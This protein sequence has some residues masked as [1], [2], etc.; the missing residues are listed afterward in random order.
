MILAPTLA[1]NTPARGFDADAAAFAAR[2]GATDVAALSAFVKG[3]KELGLWN[4]MVCWPLRSS[5]NAGTGTTAY[6]LGGLGTFNGTLVNGPTWGADG[7][8][9]ASASSQSISTSLILNVEGS[10]AVYSTLGGSDQALFSNRP[11]GSWNRGTT[12]FA[13]EASDSVALVDVAG[14]A[15]SRIRASATPILSQFVF[16]QATH[17]S[18]GSDTTSDTTFRHNKNSRSTGSYVLGSGQ[19]ATSTE[20]VRLLAA[21][22]A[23]TF[24][25]FNGTISFLF[26]LSQRPTSLQ[27]E[28]IYDLYKQTLGSGLGLP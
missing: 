12:L 5:Q 8:A 25:Y 26:L 3:V 23:S 19:M 11:T 24:G 2:S 14:D 10:G 7:L 18:V 16:T 28:S 6:S 21:S 1:L 27:Q 20:Q 4:N 13:R 15:G 9:A 22:S 17:T